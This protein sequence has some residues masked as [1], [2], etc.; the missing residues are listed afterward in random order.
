MFQIC[1]LDL[2]GKVGSVMQQPNHSNIYEFTPMYISRTL[3]NKRDA[4]AVASLYLRYNIW[5]DYIMTELN[6]STHLFLY[7]HTWCMRSVGNIWVRDYKMG[8]NP[9]QTT[10]KIEPFDIGSF[11]DNLCAVPN[12]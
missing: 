9:F 6:I 7:I 2:F 4:Y 10:K 3:Y 1:E 5:E 8:R 11:G 12:I